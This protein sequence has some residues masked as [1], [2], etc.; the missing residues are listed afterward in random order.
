MDFIKKLLSSS[1]FDTIL[2]IVDW[3]IKQVIFISVHNIITSADLAYLFIL[4]VFSKHRVS[5]YIT[6]DRGLEF[7]SDSSVL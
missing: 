7:M 3:L 2:I 5:S 1:R 6:F 4:H